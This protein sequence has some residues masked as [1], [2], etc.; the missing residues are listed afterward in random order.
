M[1]AL[2]YA[3]RYWRTDLKGIILLDPNF[4]T[5]GYPVIGIGRLNETNTFNLTA[6][7]NSMSTNLNW[8]YDPYAT[9]KPRVAYALQN[10]SAPAQYPLGNSPFTQQ[11]SH[12]RHMDQ[13]N[14]VGDLCHEL[15]PHHRSLRKPKPSRYTL[16]QYRIFCHW[17]FAFQ[18]M[19][20]PIG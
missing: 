17:N 1:A 5:A 8:T 3:T 7:I 15:T 6:A 10:P 11:P 16:S 9:L 14:R 12:Q 18:A 13:H 19:A 20:L 4:Y 2:N